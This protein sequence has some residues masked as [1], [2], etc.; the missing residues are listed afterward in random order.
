MQSY[1]EN[2]TNSA[3]VLESDADFAVDKRKFLKNDIIKVKKQNSILMLELINRAVYNSKVPRHQPMFGFEII[4]TIFAFHTKI[5]P[6]IPASFLQTIHHLFSFLH[7][8]TALDRKEYL[9]KKH[10]KW[11]TKLIT[12]CVSKVKIPK[13]RMDMCKET[14]CKLSSTVL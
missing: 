4:N 7:W 1:S 3:T 6:A 8:K 2:C 5:C 9:P 11:I 14:V 10:Q 13:I 12:N